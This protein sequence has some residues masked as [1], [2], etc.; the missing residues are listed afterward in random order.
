MS[1][2]EVAL[3]LSDINK[4]DGDGVELAVAARTECPRT[5]VL[6][7]SASATAETIKLRRSIHDKGGEA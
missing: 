4:P 7:M 3:I 6:L 5:K 2:I 1:S